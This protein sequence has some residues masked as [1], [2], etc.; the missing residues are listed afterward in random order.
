MRSILL[1][2]LGTLVATT[3][4]AQEPIKLVGFDA[5][6]FSSV[7]DGRALAGAGYDFVS[8]LFKSAGVPFVSEGQPIQRLLESLDRGNTVAIYLVR[9]PA[10]EDKY[11]WIGGLVEENAFAFITL[12]DRPR[13]DD[14]ETARGLKMV[15]AI[16]SPAVKNMLVSNGVT[17][18]D[19]TAAEGQNL[20]KLLAGRFDAWFTTNTVARYMVK[21][22][23]LPPTSVS[24][25][26]ELVPSPAWMVGSKSLPAETVQ[27]L[28]AAF[29]AAKADGRYAAFRAKLN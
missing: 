26:K 18:I 12:P 2:V 7:S 6:P 19:E 22:A 3:S 10:R 21:D 25:G 20:K 11:T 16:N 9:T 4:L 8:D 1:G 27:K 5:L 14:F 29:A 15:G 28:Q 13:V 24:V 23:G 17:A